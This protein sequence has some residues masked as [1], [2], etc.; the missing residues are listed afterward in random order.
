MIIFDK[1]KPPV[2]VLKSRDSLEI[3]DIMYIKQIKR[4]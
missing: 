4:K 1:L 3:Q 2:K